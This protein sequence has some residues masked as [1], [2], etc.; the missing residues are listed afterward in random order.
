MGEDDAPFNTAI[1]VVYWQAVRERRLKGNT[2]K[3]DAVQYILSEFLKSLLSRSE[4]SPNDRVR[5]Q[6]LISI[7]WV[8]VIGQA[9]T[10]LLVYFGLG[11]KLPLVP[12][13]S[14]VAAFALFNIFLSIRRPRRS[15]LGDRE[16]R[17]H[18]SLD[19][20]QHSGLLFF[21]GGMANP[22]TLLL[23]IPIT[24]SSSTL[25]RASTLTLSGLSL[26]C[27]SIITF[28]HFPLPFGAGEFDFLPAYMVGLWTALAISIILLAAYN[29][30]IAEE[31]RRM[32]DA[33]SATQV[34]LSRE[35]RLSELGALAAAVT[36]DMGSPLAT[37]AVVSKEI[38]R[39]LPK[40]FPLADDISLLISQGARCRDIL[41]KLAQKPEK[42]R[43]AVL[44]RIHIS[45]LVEAAAEPQKSP[46][47][48]IVFEKRGIDGA[49]EKTVAE[50]VLAQ[51]AE[52][53]HG[54]GSLV[55][56]AVQFAASKVVVTTG[57]DESQV[58]VEIHDDG[59]G[60]SPQIV[61]RLGEPY[62][63]TH[64][65]KDGHMGLGIFISQTLLTRTGAMII[66]D[67][68]ERGGAKVTVKWPREV[69]ES[70]D[71]KSE[72]RRQDMD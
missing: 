33:L 54:L 45:A 52:F 46:S 25:S 13:L 6:T 37:I 39:N 64:S 44:D 16:A 1:Y 27:I 17:L 67:N 71:A 41:A 2:E 15:W 60:F 47:V 9:F 59:P 66:F 5:L 3:T 30:T 7:R 26:A 51:T 55:Q 22:F 21:T 8:A 34:A 10:I 72:T 62:I 20:L 18:L 53:M 14:L 57:W 4:R 40:D 28:W 69:L 58:F 49:G 11:Y 12:T 61:H 70:G 42:D 23:L 48:E 38:A 65:G 50:P 68:H 63:S 36:H 19:V 32:S 29:W 56:N 31:G 35:Q 24:I 43:D